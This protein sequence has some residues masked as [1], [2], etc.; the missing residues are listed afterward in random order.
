MG[1]PHAC[2]GEPFAGVMIGPSSCVFPTRVGVNRKIAHFAGAGAGIP[3][4]CGGEPNN[5]GALTPPELY[6]PRVW[7]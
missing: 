3:H 1:I 5:P 7:G 6:S 2:G 4:A